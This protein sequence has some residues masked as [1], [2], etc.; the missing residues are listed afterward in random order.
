MGIVAVSCS[1]D[2]GRAALF[3]GGTTVAAE[4]WSLNYT[5]TRP[6]VAQE[7]DN[8]FVPYELFTE[9]I[10]GRHEELMEKWVTCGNA[11]KGQHLDGSLVL[12]NLQQMMPL[13]PQILSRDLL[14]NLSV[15]KEHFEQP[16]D[17][18]KTRGVDKG[19]RGEK[20]RG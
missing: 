18:S 9:A 2:P 16:G 19:A 8:L 13:G 11:L 10:G 12:S 3:G 14:H 20:G 5:R 6:E 4:T 17:A 1:L 7:A 15:E